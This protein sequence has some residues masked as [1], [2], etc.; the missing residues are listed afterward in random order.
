M[1][2][3]WLSG[4]WPMSCKAGSRGSALAGSGPLMGR[5]FDRRGV[6]QFQCVQRDQ[7]QRRSAVPDHRVRVHGSFWTDR[8]Q[9]HRD[10]RRT[11]RVYV[12]R[13]HAGELDHDHST[14]GR[15]GRRQR[16]VSGGG[17]SRSGCPQRGRCRQRPVSRSLP[18]SRA[19]LVRGLPEYRRYWCRRRHARY[20]CQDE[21]RLFM[22]G[23]HGCPVGDAEP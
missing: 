7:S 16:V 19:L 10:G 20:R 5:V 12:G 11:A 23:K 15:A 6:R 9:R 2:A 8:R 14:S 13:F 18:R 21:R 17:E 22:D 3:P 1:R 4:F